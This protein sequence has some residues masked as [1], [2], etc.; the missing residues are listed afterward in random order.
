M[1][2]TRSFHKMDLDMQ[3]KNLRETSVRRRFH[4]GIA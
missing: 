3:H 4:H 1:D 2:E